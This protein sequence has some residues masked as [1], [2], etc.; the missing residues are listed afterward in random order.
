MRALVVGRPKFPV[1]AEQLPELVEAALSWHQRY[2]DS[3]EA[4]GTFIGGGGF[5][6]VNVPD[7]QALNQIVIEMPFSSV[8]ELEVRP[9][10]EGTVGFRQLQ[11]ALAAMGAGQGATEAPEP[12]S[13][14]EA[15]GRSAMASYVV[16]FNWT[17][18]GVRS[19]RDSPGRVEAFNQEMEGLGVRLKEVYWTLGPHDLVG[20][21]EAADDETVTAALL[22][23]ATGGNVRTTTLRAFNA[24]EFRALS[25][26]VG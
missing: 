2:R 17:E 11:Q 24:D 22:K 3:F 7:E 15:E 16:L 21:I 23:L 10:V 20:V 13:L 4:F 12:V 25:E 1:S 5:A 18:Q 14:A 9:F 6:V 26:K 8:S 19:F